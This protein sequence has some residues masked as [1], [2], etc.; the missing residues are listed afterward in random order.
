VDAPCSG[1]GTVRRNPDLKWRQSPVSVE[2]MHQKQTSILAAASSLVKAGGRLVYATCSL[3]RE[4]NEDIVE[5]FLETHADFRALDCG[6]ILRQQGVDIELSQ[7]MRLWPH[8]HGTDGFFG[9]AFERSHLAPG[10]RARGQ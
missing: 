3:L 8:V 9:A 2:E 4:E 7:R 6:E 5:R 1:L 10:A